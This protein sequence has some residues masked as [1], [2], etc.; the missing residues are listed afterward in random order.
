MSTAVAYKMKADGRIVIPSE[1]RK[2]LG[3][4]AGDNVILR[5]EEGSVRI[6]AITNAI[7]RA[8]KMCAKLKKPGMSIVDELIEER[9]KEA[10]KEY[11]A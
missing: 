4:Q 3:I 2:Q 6:M 9:R 1:Y 5:L 10:K 11:S 7:E 8:Q